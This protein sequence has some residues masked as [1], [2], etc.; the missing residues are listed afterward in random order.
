MNHDR[1]LTIDEEANYNGEA[2]SLNDYLHR[3]KQKD[4]FFNIRATK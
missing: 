4:K 3:T 2:D 1:C